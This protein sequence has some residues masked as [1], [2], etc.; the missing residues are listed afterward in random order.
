MRGPLR[1]CPWACLERRPPGAAL[2]TCPC[3]SPQVLRGL[4][5]LREKHQI[6]H[7]GETDGRMDGRT[8][9]RVGRG[10]A[11]GGLRATPH[12]PTLLQT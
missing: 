12:P 7:R 3:G 4:A 11:A 2:L 6:M 9:S 10:G 5:Y 1:S 8:P